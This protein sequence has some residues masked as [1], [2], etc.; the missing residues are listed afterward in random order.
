MSEHK[1][2][3]EDN[4][5]RFDAK[6][7]AAEEQEKTSPQQNPTNSDSGRRIATE[8]MSY[9]VGGGS[10]GFIIDKLL[11]TFPAFMLLVGFLGFS[12]SLYRAYKLMDGGSQKK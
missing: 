3:D 12:I 7:E 4:I 1:D 9:P 5:V 2:S 6:L 11:G 8:I 10:L